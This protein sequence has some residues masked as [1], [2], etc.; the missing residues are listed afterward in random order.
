MAYTLNCSVTHWR[1][2][3]LMLVYII[4]SVSGIIRYSIP[5]ELKLRSVVGNIAKDLGLDVNQ[6]S[7]RGFRVVSEYKRQYLDVNLNTGILFIKET[8]DREEICEQSLGCVLMLEAVVEN[9]LK[10][11]RVEVEILDINDN[12][13]VFQENE[14]HFQLAEYVSAGARFQ[15]QSALDPD[16]GTNGVQTYQLSESDHFILELK[17][18]EQHTVTPELVLQKPLDREQQATHQ[19]T[20]TAIDGGTPEKSGTTHILINVSDVNDNAPVFEQT[21]YKVTTSE[22]VPKDSV[23]A[24]VTANDVDEGLNGEIAYSLSDRTPGRFRSLFRVNSQ[25]GEIGVKGVVDFEE[26]K[27][28]EIS[29]QALDRGPHAV[30]AYCTVLIKVLD[31]NDNAPEITVTSNSGPIPEDAP[32]KTPV[33]LLKVTDQ[34]SEERG[35][36][37]CYIPQNIPFNLDRSFSNYYTVVLAGHLDREKVPEY[38]ITITCRDRG[39]PPLTNHKTIHIHVSDVNDN[40]PHFTKPSFVMYVT[41]NNRIGA[42][43][44]SVSA[45]D[46]D[47]DENANLFYSIID[48]PVSGFA[49]STFASINSATGVMSARRSFD[50]EQ[51]KSFQLSVQVKDSGTPPLSENVTVNVIIV[52]QNDNAPVIASPLTSGGSKAEETMPRSADPGYLVAKVTATDADSGQNALLFYQLLH[53]N[54]ESL[55]TV[56][57]ET[58]EIWTIRRFGLR[59]LP[60][61][62]LHILV[63]D[64]GKPSLS[65]TA[66][67]TV[68]VLE[69]N[70]EHASTHGLLGNSEPWTSDLRRYL[71]ISFAAISLIFLI[72]IIILAMKIHRGRDGIHDCSCSWPILIQKDARRGIHKPGGNVPP[73]PDFTGVYE[74]DTLPQTVQYELCPDPTISDFMFLQLHGPAAPMINIKTGSCVSQENEKTLNSTIKGS[75]ETR[76]IYG[77]RQQDLEQSTIERCS[78]GQYGIGLYT[79]E[80]Y[81]VGPD[82]RRLVEI[83]SR[84][85]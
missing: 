26:T 51:M 74:S 1:V 60:Q 27:D 30:P 33:A 22:N 84:A 56:S 58:G 37:H 62:Q 66:S 15:L 65:S 34:D 78:S 64:N 24:K 49:A 13:P 41:E 68:S 17:S 19:L 54:D 20:L 23:I 29:V 70:T 7:L 77:T 57:R 75:V 16:A 63:R 18:S 28:Y 80:K 61:Q 9:P 43:I 73:L 72:A 53:P 39:S 82:P 35:N 44:G 71:I 21:V 42:S 10:L 67:I 79:S 45:L 46:V 48:D 14:F 47:F 8:V 83:H 5:E 76:E 31:I 6:L 11:Y 4:H 36:V 52:D 3:Y 55:F 50:Y 12:P 59:D 32:P 38:N 81:D 2:F 85:F 69:S 25:T 40:P